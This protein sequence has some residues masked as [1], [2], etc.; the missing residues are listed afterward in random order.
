ME[1]RKTPGPTG[2]VA[3]ILPF[4]NVDGPGNR[5]AVFFQGCPFACKYCHNPE[6]KRAYCPSMESDGNFPRRMGLDDLAFLIEP[7]RP[8]IRGLTLSGG[9]A[10]VQGEF[11][12]GIVEMARRKFSLGTLIDTCGSQDFRLY[13]FLSTCEGIMLDIKAWDDTEHLGLTGKSNKVVLENFQWALKNR[14]LTEV[15]TVIAPELFDCRHTVSQVA[16]ALSEEDSDI[17]YVLIAFRP[18]GVLS[19]WNTL[20]VPDRKIMEE[21]VSLGISQGHRNIIIR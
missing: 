11:A 21:L 18:Q 13:P 8:F 4:S 19:P 17:P 10:L 15:R 12:A 7:V 6:T 5:F 3:K 1:Q 2:A 14:Y 9:E 20:P 16:R